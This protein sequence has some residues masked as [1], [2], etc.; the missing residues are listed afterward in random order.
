M[1]YEYNITPPRGMLRID[2]AELWRFR[3]LFLTLAWRD[4]SGV[5]VCKPGNRCKP[6]TVEPNN[7][8]GKRW[9]KWRDE[10]K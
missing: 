8:S 2:W 5:V 9:G 6:N 1:S 10:S 7:T 4:I 3:D